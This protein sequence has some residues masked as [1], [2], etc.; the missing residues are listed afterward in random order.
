MLPMNKAA[1]RRSVRILLV[2]DSKPI[3]REN[4]RA[5]LEAGYQV[6][7]ALDGETALRFAQEMQPELI[8]LDMILPRMS[9]PEVLDH[10]KSNAATATIPVV[11]VSSLSEKNRDKLI[12]AGAVD[13]L[14]KS[15]LLNEHG[16]NLL[17]QMLEKILARIRRERAARFSTVPARS[18]V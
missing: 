2:E 6:T 16:V 11:V 7:C 8:L 10:L 12:E 14:E 1:W 17:P 18:R 4:E 3:R 5:L 9:G 15:E 13:Y